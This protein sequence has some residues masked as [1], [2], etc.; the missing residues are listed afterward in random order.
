MDQKMLDK[1]SE[2]TTN[3]AYADAAKTIKTP[4]EMQK[5]LSDNGLEMSIED[6]VTIAK[7]F[8]DQNVKKDGEELTEEDL[9]AVAGGKVSWG[10]AFVSVV[11]IGLSVATGNVWTGTY[12]ALALYGSLRGY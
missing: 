7:A 11:G 1:F 3:E 6:I 10:H 4:E 2:I 5:F 8:V 12:C 9:Q